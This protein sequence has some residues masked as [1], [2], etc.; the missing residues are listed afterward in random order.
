MQSL[1]KSLSPPQPPHP[2][3]GNPFNTSAIGASNAKLTALQNLAGGRKKPTK[4][5]AADT[6]VGQFPGNNPAN[7]LLVKMAAL[8]GQADANRALDGNRPPL[9]KGGG[10]RTKGRKTRKSHKKRRP[11]KKKTHRRYKY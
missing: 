1:T 2:T 5:G 3:G 8:G 6:V 9:P 11:H 10:G 7:P 4:G